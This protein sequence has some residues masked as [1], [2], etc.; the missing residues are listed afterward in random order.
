MKGNKKPYLRAEEKPDRW[1]EGNYQAF[2][3]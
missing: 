1:G 2:V 3:L